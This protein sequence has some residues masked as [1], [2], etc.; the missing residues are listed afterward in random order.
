MVTLNKAQKSRKIEVMA[1]QATTNLAG[2]NAFTLGAHERLVER[3]LG[4]FWSENLFYANGKKLSQEIIADIQ[5][6]AK[7]DPEF[8]LRLAAYARNEMYL[9]TTPQVLLVVAANLT[10]TKSFVRKY[11]PRII[12]RADELTEVVAFQLLQYG[13]PIPNSLKRGIA[14]AFANFDEYQLNKYDSDTGAVKLSDVLRLV[15]RRKNYPVSEALRDYIVNDKVDTEAL[16]KIAA[17]KALLAKATL[18][19]EALEL[20]QKS[21]VTWETFISKFGSNKEN[22]ERVSN[23]MGYMALLRNLRNF[24]KFEV[25]NIEEIAK[26]IADP[27]QVKKS[28][29]LPFRF[30]SAIKA[31]TNGVLETAV[32]KALDASLSNM[33]LSGKTAIIVDLSGSMEGKL[34]EK[35]DVS[36]K[37]IA[38]V[39]GAV[40]SK[41]SPESIVIGFANS[42]KKIE[43]KGYDPVVTSVQ[44]IMHTQ[45]GGSTFAHK[46]FELLGTDVKYD[47][48]ILISD[49]QCY[50]D[51]SI[52]VR[53]SYYGNTS[54]NALWEEYRKKH[55]ATK[56]YSLDVSAYGTS[57]LPKW[58]GNNVVQLWG[59]S[60]KLIDFMKNSEGK[61]SLLETISAY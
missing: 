17:L 40:A 22:W 54:V 57:Q 3:V 7:T 33:D 8:I 56:L 20:V 30:Y 1:E 4:A 47:R 35:S 41:K 26:R 25:G 15:D 49:M 51:A 2:S 37:E 6:V 39:L 27:V 55:P 50:D 21:G 34:S 14:D 53:S 42:A 23:N 24:E 28:K 32:A 36:Y 13:K 46:A 16:P 29:Q 10:E 44:K 38:A 45:V 5:T 18:D 48:I 12:R 61:S 58:A 11:A 43:V 19:D 9:R 59:W 31:V 52:R 60:D